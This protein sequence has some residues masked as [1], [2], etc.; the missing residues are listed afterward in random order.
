MHTPCRLSVAL[1]D[2][3]EARRGGPVGGV[4]VSVRVDQVCL[5]VSP[6]ALL[7]LGHPALQAI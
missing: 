7:P 3:G 1:L 4:D 6:A 5:C 2:G